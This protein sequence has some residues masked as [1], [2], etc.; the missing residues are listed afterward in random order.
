MN[1]FDKIDLWL[2]R[3]RISEISPEEAEEIGLQRRDLSEYLDYCLE[4]RDREGLEDM[5]NSTHNVGFHISNDERN[6]MIY[7]WAYT[8]RVSPSGIKSEKQWHKIYSDYSGE[9]LEEDNKLEDRLVEGIVSGKITQ[10]VEESEDFKKY[11]QKVPR[12]TVVR[13]YGFQDNPES[14]FYGD[15]KT[16]GEVQEELDEFF[17]EIGGFPV[18]YIALRDDK[19]PS[20]RLEYAD[21]YLDP[22][23]AEKYTVGFANFSIAKD[24]EGRNKIKGKLVVGEKKYSVQGVKNDHIRYIPFDYSFEFD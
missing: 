6:S 16:V 20:F 18:D 8:Q 19:N 24:S 4:T 5:H 17:K 11:M 7:G 21:K 1:W 12:E 9:G 3:K 14:V 2:T 22:K 15:V 13:D 10:E 23:K